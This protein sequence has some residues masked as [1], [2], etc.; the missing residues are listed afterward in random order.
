MLFIYFTYF[1]YLIVDDFSYY[2]PDGPEKQS[3]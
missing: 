2:L 1:I 3:V